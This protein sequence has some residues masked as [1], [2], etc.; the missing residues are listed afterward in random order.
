MYKRILFSI[1]PLALAASGAWAQGRGEGGAKPPALLFREEWKQTPKGG[2]HAVSVS[3]AVSNPELEMK[4]YGPAGKDIQLT[5]VAGNEANPIHLWTGLCEANCAVAL[6]DKNNYVDL[7]GLAKIR[8]LVKVS[9]FHQVHPILKLANGTWL[10]GDHADGS[11][12]DW[13][14]YEFSLADVRW[15][16]LDIEKVAPKGVWVE[17]P[18]LSKVDEIGFTDLMAGSGHGPGGWSDVAWI[19]VYGKPV[20]RDAGGAGQ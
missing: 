7:T 2:E 5:G 6:R 8:W 17:K 20:K 4:L 9:G 1:L 11:T 14:P 12:V 10:V 18:D 13:H 19:E 3:E 15:L 16:R